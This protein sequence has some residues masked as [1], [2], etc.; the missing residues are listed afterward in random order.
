TLNDAPVGALAHCFPSRIFIWGISALPQVYL[1]ALQA[2]D[3]HTEIYLLFTNPCRYYWGDIQDP[4]FLA[5]LN[6]RKP[7][8]YQQLHELPWFKNEQNASTLFN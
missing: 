5:R 8:H 4:K 3:R 6:S 2:I 7:R 1:Q